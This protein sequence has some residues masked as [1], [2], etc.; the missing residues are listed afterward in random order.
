M[1]AQV[2]R[3]DLNGKKARIQE[4][5]RASSEASRGRCLSTACGFRGHDQERERGMSPCP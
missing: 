3:A 2:S 5:R 1:A 4:L